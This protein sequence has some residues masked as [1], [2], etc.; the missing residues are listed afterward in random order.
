MTIQ[1]KNGETKFTNS[2]RYKC[3]EHLRKTGLDLYLCYCGIEECDPAHAY[4]PTTRDEYLL[5]YILDGEG[6]FTINGMTKKLGKHQIFLITP[7]VVTYYKA[8]AKNPWTYIWIGFN[9]TKAKT[10]LEYANFNE[11]N[12]TGSFDDASILLSYVKHMLDASKLTS[13]NE[14]KREGYLFLFLS[15]LMESCG[16]ASGNRHDYSYQIYVEHALEYI[17]HNYQK[18]IHVTDIAEYIGVTRSYLTMCFQK[19][20]NTSPQQYL[21]QYRMEKAKDLLKTTNMAINVIATE[22]GYDNALAFS[23]IFRQTCNMAP[24]AFREK[25]ETTIE[26]DV[27]PEH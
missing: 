10:Y 11:D 12:V 3:L 17:E 13:A 6:T 8:D 15:A 20:L 14:L 1:Q 19:S 5:H 26:T 16:D 4:G 2:A 27:I 7:K 23:R 18:E 21:I 9:G 24:K 25:A 22:V